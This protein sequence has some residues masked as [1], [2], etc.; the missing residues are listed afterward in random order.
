MD[1]EGK[2]SNSEKLI[3]ENDH[4]AEKFTHENAGV[5]QFYECIFCK[6]G[7]TNAQAMG[8]VVISTFFPG[9]NPNFS[10]RYHANDYADPRPERLSLFGDNEDLNLNLKIDPDEDGVCRRKDTRKENEMD[11][12]RILGKRMRWIWNFVSVRLVP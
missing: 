1:Y 2:P 8:G 7:F 4:P 3:E 6:R 5:S 10:E 12:E 11:L 9:S